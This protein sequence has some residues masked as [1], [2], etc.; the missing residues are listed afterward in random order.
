ESPMQALV[1]ATSVNADILGV[2][3]TVGMVR[4]GMRADLAVWQRDPLE[5]PSVFANPEMA[6]LVVKSG[7]TVKDIR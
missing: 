3:D 7:S 2:G 6:V 4:V 5:D 1:S